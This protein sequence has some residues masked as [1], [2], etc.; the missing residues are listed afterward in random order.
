MSLQFQFKSLVSLFKKNI[1]LFYKF[2]NYYIYTILSAVVAF[3][4]ISYLTHEINESGYGHLGIFTSISFVIPNLLSFNTAALVQ[5]NIVNLAYGKY[6]VFRNNYI[7]FC[8]SIFIFFEFIALTFSNLWQEYNSIVHFSLIYGFLL[9]LSSIHNGELIQRGKATQFG[10]LNFLSATLSLLISI[11]LISIF[12]FEWEG[13]ILSFISVEVLF[14]IIRFTALSDIWKKFKITL[15]IIEWKYFLK[16]GSMLWLGLIAGWIINQSDRFILLRYLT[17]EDVGIYSAGAGISGFLIMINTTMVK[18]LAPIIY[19]ALK[20]KR[21]K[22]FILKFFVFYAVLIFIIALVICAF[23]LLFLPYFFG[24]KYLIAKWIICILTMAQAFFG[25]YQIVGLVI[26]Y[27]KLNNLKSI[28]VSICAISCLITGITL[29]P[30]FGINAPAIGNLISFIL[31]AFLTY[32]FANKHLVR[33]SKVE[34][35]YN[36]ENIN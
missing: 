8:T 7:T 2:L 33:L 11:I 10:L 3:G 5:I 24:E 26:D 14:L 29:I 15:H 20:E 34:S 32:Y 9:L 31:L 25:M 19:K 16:Y 35:S 21:N 18:V 22:D 23:T 6:I 4:S 28:I 17:I 36:G 13:R 27:L 30:F 1:D 12:H